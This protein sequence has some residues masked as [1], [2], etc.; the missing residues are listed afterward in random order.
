MGAVL[1]VDL[2]S[3]LLVDGR[4]RLLE[5]VGSGAT[6][7]VFRAQD[8]RR[9]RKLALKVLHPRWAEDGPTVER[10][11]R[12]ASNA[13]RLGHPNVVRVYDCGACDG[14]HYIAMEYVPGCSLKA[15]IDR[16]APLHPAR[17]IDLT[18]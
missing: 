11:R 3:G 16:E 1:S 5:R 6:A 17:A 14:T 2:E 7:D 12:E 9:E 10:F 8:L 18:V 4:Y 13:A 15:L